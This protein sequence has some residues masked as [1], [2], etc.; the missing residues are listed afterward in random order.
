MI[1]DGLE[2]GDIVLINLDP[3]KGSEQAGLR[4]CLVVSERLMHGFSK[5]AIVC[6][7]TRN[8]APWPTKVFCRRG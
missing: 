5:R 8:M 2:A 1:V 4:P 3:T 7:V 6:P